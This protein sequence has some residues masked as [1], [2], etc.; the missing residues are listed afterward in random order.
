LK[1]R[2]GCIGGAF[3]NAFGER[4]R[5]RL[6]HIGG[7]LEGALGARALRVHL[8]HIESVDGASSRTYETR[9]P[10]GKGTVLRGVEKVDTVPLPQRTRDRKHTV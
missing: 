2:W 4:W 6:G 7:T 8:R 9:K 10:V 5:A 1:T 3:E